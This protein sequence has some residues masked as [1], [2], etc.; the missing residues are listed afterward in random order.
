MAIAPMF[1][2][3]PPGAQCLVI[4]T[5]RGIN[6]LILSRSI[7]IRIISEIRIERLRRRLK[8]PLRFKPVKAESEIQVPRFARKNVHFFRRTYKL[9]WV[10]LKTLKL[11]GKTTKMVEPIFI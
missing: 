7:L 3:I 11:K 4:Q 9:P 5:S 2:P 10:K 8:L 1:L 6:I